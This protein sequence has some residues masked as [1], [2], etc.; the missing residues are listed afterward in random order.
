MNSNPAYATPAKVN[1]A[2]TVFN[3]IIFIVGLIGMA[4]IEGM[5]FYKGLCFGFLT[6]GIVLLAANVATAIL[7]TKEPR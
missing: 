1:G 3:L 7:I 5:N 6:S 2:F 4:N